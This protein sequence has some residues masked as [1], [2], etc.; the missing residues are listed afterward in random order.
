[1]WKKLSAIALL[2]SVV[3]SS[4]DAD[5]CINETLRMGDPAV[6]KMVE[7]ERLVDAGN[8]KDATSWVKSANAG[9][10]KSKLGAGPLSDRGL[11]VLVRAA[12]RS[13]GADY[14]G[15]SSDTPSAEEKSAAL[16]WAAG[17]VKEMYEKQSSDPHMTSLFAE[18]LVRSPREQPRVL[19]LLEPLEKADVLPSAYGYAALAK[20]RAETAAEKPAFLRGPLVAL[21]SGKRTLALARCERMVKDTAICEG[22]EPARV[23]PSQAGVQAVLNENARRHDFNVMVFGTRPSVLVRS[24]TAASL[25]DD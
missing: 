12:I 13:G 1:M 4:H 16:G 21:E 2:G 7:A 8:T 15:H 5:A 18:S 14:L 3:L 17:L 23:P 6:A 10:A 9:F 22:R 25:G 11:S 20:A 19:K 24:A